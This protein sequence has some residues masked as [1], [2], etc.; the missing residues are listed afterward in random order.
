MV[1]SVKSNHPNAGEI[2]VQGHLVVRGI[3]VQRNRV[4]SAIHETDPSLSMRKRPPI[5]RRA[6]FVPCPNYL[7]HIDGNHKMI[8]WHFVIHHGIDGFS[9]LVMFCRCSGNNRATTVFLPFQE[10]VHKY[11]RPIRVRTDHGE[12]NICIWRDMTASHGEEARSVIVG[13]SVHKQRIERHNR[14]VNEQVIAMFKADFYQLER[15]DVLDPLNDVDL[16]C[17]HLCK[18]L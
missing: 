5:N 4:R 14:A 15:E 16:F 11:G 13:S 9:R 8:R 7:W 12:E 1:A 18:C 6:Y 17:L 3:D 2:M 10:A